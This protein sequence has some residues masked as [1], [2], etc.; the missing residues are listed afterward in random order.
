MAQVF[1]LTVGPGPP[2]AA[3]KEPWTQFEIARPAIQYN[4]DSGTM[5][6]ASHSADSDPS[7]LLL[8]ITC[9]LSC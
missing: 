2:V 7:R 8:P 4:M 1:A 5:P 3:G 9:E 6:H